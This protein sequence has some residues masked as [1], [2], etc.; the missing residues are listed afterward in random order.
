MAATES[1]ATHHSHLRPE[2]PLVQGVAAGEAGMGIIRD[3]AVSGGAGRA[4]SLRC[5]ASAVWKVTDVL[6]AFF[7]Y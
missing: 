2:H 5:M 4:A 1:V 7:M 6:S 3:T